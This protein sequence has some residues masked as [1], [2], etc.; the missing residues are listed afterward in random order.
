VASAK[1]DARV[2]SNNFNAHFAPS[3]SIRELEGWVANTRMAIASSK[4]D[5]AVDLREVNVNPANDPII[6]ARFASSKCDYRLE[7]E[8][9]LHG[10]PR[11]RLGAAA[12]AKCDFR[13]IEAS[14]SP[15]LK[16]APVPIEPPKPTRRKK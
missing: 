6:A 3:G 15:N 10:G 9:G 4:C 11:Y 14:F 7:V 16:S 8:F 1:C 12:S 13:L 2:T 5:W